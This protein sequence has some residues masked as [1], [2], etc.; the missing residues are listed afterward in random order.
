MLLTTHKPFSIELVWF[1]NNILS[2]LFNDKLSIPFIF[3]DTVLNAR[4]NDD[5]IVGETT[6]L[7][8]LTYLDIIELV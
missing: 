7:L 3:H 5:N 6:I 8:K 1:I 4:F 2:L